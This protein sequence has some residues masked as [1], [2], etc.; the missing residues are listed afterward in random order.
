[1]SRNKILSTRTQFSTFP[2]EVM[3]TLGAVQWKKDNEMKIISL[4]VVTKPTVKST[5]QDICFETTLAHGLCSQYL[6]GLNPDDV[7][8]FYDSRSSAEEKARWL[9]HQSAQK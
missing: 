6:G 3:E 4:W 9:L 2:R 8:A 5:L 7:V 1:M